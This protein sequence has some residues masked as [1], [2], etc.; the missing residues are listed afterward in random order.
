MIMTLTVKQYKDAI[1]NSL[2]SRQIETLQLLYY[3]PNS[4]AKARTLSRLLGSKSEEAI[5]ANGAIGRIGRSFSN[6]LQITLDDDTAF[7]E[8]IGP[9]TVNGWEMRKNLKRALEELGLTTQ[10]NGGTEI[11][12]RLPTEVLSFEESQLLK[13]GK[14]IQVY[15]DRYERNQKARLKCIDNFG[16]KCYV[17]GFDFGKVYGDIA[18][19]FIHVHHIRQLSEIKEE[20]KVDPLIDL[21]PVCANCH[22]VIHVTKPAMTIQKIKRRVGKK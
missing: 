18:K 21:I 19:G 1:R 2:S 15:V 20:Y 6:Y 17:C 3:S 16:D 11:S 8:L 7:Y 9:Y 22:S 14:V 12:D 4:T 13:E 5:V 10:D